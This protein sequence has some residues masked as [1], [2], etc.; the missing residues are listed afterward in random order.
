MSEAL[1]AEITGCKA[2]YQ[3]LFATEAECQS[4]C[5]L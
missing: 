4:N 1:C 2:P 5:D 3:P